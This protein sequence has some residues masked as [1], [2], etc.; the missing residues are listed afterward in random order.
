[1]AVGKLAAQNH[2]VLTNAL[3]RFKPIMAKWAA[4]F[5]IQAGLIKFI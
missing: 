4:F 1:M 5:V 3:H 2:T